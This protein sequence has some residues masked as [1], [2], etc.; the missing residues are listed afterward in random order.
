ELPLIVVQ[1]LERA[2]QQLLSGVQR[3]LSLFVR[4]LRS[5]PGRG[6]AIIYN[7]G[8]LNGSRGKH[9][10]IL[11]RWVTV[12]LAEALLAGTQIRFPARRV[13]E[14]ALEVPRP[15]ILTA[16]GGLVVQVFPADNVLPALAASCAPAPDGPLFSALETAG[17]I[18]LCDPSWHLTS[19]KA[20]PVRYKP[21]NR[22]VI[23]YRLLLERTTQEGILQQD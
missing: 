19:V 3:Q 2:P 14:A 16:D 9:T 4:Y 15:G 5:K 21:S 6:L 22:C 20:E 11:D 12:T 23:R 18:Q 8:A 1:L 13:Q 17:R 10:N 7:A